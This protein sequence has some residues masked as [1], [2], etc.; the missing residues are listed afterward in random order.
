MLLLYFCYG[1]SYGGCYIFIRNWRFFLDIMFQLIEELLYRVGAW[2]IRNA[3]LDCIF[4]LFDCITHNIATYCD[5]YYIFAF[6]A[7]CFS[8]LHFLEEKER[9]LIDL[10]F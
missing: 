10:S 7:F 8:F 4:G 1:F 3:V 5:E 9:M 6:F 2:I